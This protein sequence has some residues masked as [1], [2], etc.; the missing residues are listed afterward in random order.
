MTNA[1]SVLELYYRFHHPELLEDDELLDII[2]T[3]IIVFI[4]ARATRP[5]NPLRRCVL[6]QISCMQC[7]LVTCFH[8]EMVQGDSGFA[9]LD[10]EGMNRSW[11][12]VKAF[13]GR[14]FLLRQKKRGL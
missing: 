6:S 11:L 3:I 12:R 14:S 13:W 5:K 4:G 7:V 9:S 8:L 1:G 2:I 10:L